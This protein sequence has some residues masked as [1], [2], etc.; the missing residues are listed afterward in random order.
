MPMSPKRA[1]GSKLG[2]LS[3]IG[4]NLEKA[5]F[6]LGARSVLTWG[7]ATLLIGHLACS[8]S[9]EIPAGAV[10]GGGA[11]A[12]GTQGQSAAGGSLGGA[13]NGK[14]SNGGSD[15]SS[16]SGGAALGGMSGAGGSMLNGGAAP[17]GTVGAGGSMLNG[18]AT[19]GGTVGAGGSTVNGGAAPGGTNGTGG[20]S[21]SGGGSSGG[22]ANG[23][24]SGAG[25]GGA[26]VTEPYRIM[27]FGDSITGTTCYPQLLSQD[28][29]ADGRTNFE[30]VGTVLNNQS[31]DG[32]PFVQTEG[33]GGYQITNLVSGGAN[34][35]ELGPWLEADR[36]EVV[37]MHFGTNDI[38][39]SKTTDAILEAFSQAI[40]AMRS[41]T[42]EVVVF[43]AQILPMT[44][45]N[46][47][48]C[49]ARVQDL[50]ARI[51]EW[52]A[53][54]SRPDSPV[55]VVDQYSN[56]DSATLTA[57]GVHPTITGAQLMAD[58]WSSALLAHG[59]P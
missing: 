22:A 10:G 27:A 56:F 57:D 26:V 58:R 59:L 38:W 18:G 6:G 21:V 53:N 16:A 25:A 4:W 47:P 54:E 49:P 51:P 2:S 13:G 36:A 7:G 44:P 11:E 40:A 50:N 33:H 29:L 42:P 8:S 23:G 41:V 43:V 5:I 17:G 9:Q 32:A 48:L 39:N 28:L 37:L 46:C 55:Y 35:S 30:F 24:A 15:G 12:A 31:C 20:L 52:S 14:M 19:P 3:A 1:V 45:D 34:A